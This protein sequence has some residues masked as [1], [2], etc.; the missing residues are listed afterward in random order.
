[1]LND[2]LQWII[3]WYNSQCDGDWEHSGG[4][5][6][7]TLGNPGWNVTIRIEE[8]ELFDK[9]FQEVSINRTA[10]DWYFC[11]VENGFFQAYCGTP[12]LIEVLQ[13]FRDW[14]EEEGVY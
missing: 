1:M 2:N 4:I 12:N 7:D 13:I 8:T 5:H 10:T 9:K 6:I 3:N 11:K 14:A